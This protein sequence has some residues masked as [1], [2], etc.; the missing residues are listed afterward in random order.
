MRRST[1]QQLFILVLVAGLVY[2][3]YTLTLP[4]DAPALVVAAHPAA[5]TLVRLR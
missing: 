2:G 5:Q 4:A 3:I 1:K